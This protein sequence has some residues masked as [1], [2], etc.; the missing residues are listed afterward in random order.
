[1]KRDSYADFMIAIGIVC[2]GLW[3]VTLWSCPEP[4]AAAGVLLATEEEILRGDEIEVW[5]CPPI[6]SGVELEFEQSFT[7][8]LVV[9]TPEEV[10]RGWPTPDFWGTRVDLPP[11]TRLFYWTARTIDFDAEG[12][13]QT[14]EFAA[15]VPEPDRWL[16]M[17]TG[18][19]TVVLL[20]WW[21]RRR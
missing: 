4:A 5:V 18:L 20:W 3:V 15:W 19:C 16:M 14:G 6:C 17:L 10:M 21:R 1:M 12:P 8:G 13:A 9:T 2:L 7:P 11:Y